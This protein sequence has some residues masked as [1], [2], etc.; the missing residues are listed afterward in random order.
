[1]W[2]S[3]VGL[4]G[5]NQPSLL[6]LR[7]LLPLVSETDGTKLTLE[8]PEE[9]FWLCVAR[10]TDRAL[11]FLNA[12]YARIIDLES[13]PSEVAAIVDGE[14]KRIGNGMGIGW[15]FGFEAVIYYTGKGVRGQRQR[16]LNGQY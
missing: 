12:N 13:A 16:R 4:V 15:F 2:F 3:V 6:F 11:D 7:Q 14:D 1:M 5:F 10:P 9:V 8:L